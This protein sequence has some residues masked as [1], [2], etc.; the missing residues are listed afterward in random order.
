MCGSPTR[1]Y[2]VAEANEKSKTHTYRS[3]CILNTAI[4]QP[5]GRWVLSLPDTATVILRPMWLRKDGWHPAGSF[6][7]SHW[8]AVTVCLALYA[9]K[10][11]HSW[12]RWRSDRYSDR[13]KLRNEEHAFWRER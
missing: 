7:G 11:R 6:P 10:H 5:S 2:S 13:A 1:K 9:L 8:S 3:Q 4:T 12:L